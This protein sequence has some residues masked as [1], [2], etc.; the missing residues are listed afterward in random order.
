MDLKDVKDAITAMDE[1]DVIEI[2]EAVLSNPHVLSGAIATE[3][4]AYTKIEDLFSQDYDEED[5]SAE[6]VFDDLIDSLNLEDDYIT[7]LCELDS[8]L[9][10][11]ISLAL[12]DI[13]EKA[14]KK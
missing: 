14:V 9:E 4:D 12:D 10:T 7:E 3:S 6:D 1:N 11:D 5:N 2:F 8:K 13:A